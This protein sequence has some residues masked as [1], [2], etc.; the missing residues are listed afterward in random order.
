MEEEIG[1]ITHYFAK[2]N[3]GKVKMTKE[4]GKLNV[5]DTI[6]VKGQST[7]FYQK[8]KSLQLNHSPVESVGLG[9]LV[10]LKVDLAARVKDLVFK[11]HME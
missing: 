1:L 4:N 5:G 11:V 7:D 8:V 9:D 3:V 2:I 6:H 10:G